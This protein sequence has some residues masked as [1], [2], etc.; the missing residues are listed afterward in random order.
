MTLGHDHYMARCVELARCAKSRGHAPVGSIVVFDG[1]I[2]G[3]GSESL[4]TGNVIAG[5]AEVL[6][7]QQAVDWL[8]RPDLSIA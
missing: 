6:A 4:P 2:I 8:A 7:C 1:R 5:H 3:G